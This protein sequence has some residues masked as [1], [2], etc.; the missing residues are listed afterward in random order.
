[1]KTVTHHDRT[2]AYRIADRGGDGDPVLFV[3]GSGGTH[4]LWK[5]QLSRLSS[6]I[7][8]VAID[9]SGHGESE[10]VDADP[11]W[12]TLSAYADDVLAVAEET[13]ARTLV[14]NSLG[15]AV[16]LHLVIERDFDP[17][18]LALVGS[19]AKLSVSDDLL[20]WLD[21]DF[22]RAVQFLH[23]G[24]R[25][26]HDPDD[27]YVELSKESMYDVGQRITSRDFH[28]CHT[29]D[30]R[31]RLDEIA[32]PTLAAVGEYDMLTPPWY[33][34]YLADNVRDG[35]FV[36]IEDAA[37]LAMLETPDAFNGMLTR[38]LNGVL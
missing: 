33:H 23:D 20:T 31:D 10:D 16:V 22:D 29:F 35:Q 3:H 30:V 15:G 18:A 25:L 17:D 27:R 1:M 8:I 26:F 4:E 14:G 13:G 6:S 19:G 21:S 36:E 28:S 9:L 2:T 32:A 34:E 7:P 38:F 37:H 12:S 24:D 5:A 11:G